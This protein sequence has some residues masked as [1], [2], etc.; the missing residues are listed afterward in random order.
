ADEKPWRNLSAGVVSR[1]LRDAS[2]A[3]AGTWTY[4]PSLNPLPDALHPAREAVRTVVSPLG[5]KSESFFSV[6]LDD[7]YAD[8]SK[9]DYSLPFTRFAAD[10]AGRFLS[11]RTWD[12]AAGA[13]N[14]ALER[15]TYVAYERD[16]GL[17]NGSDFQANMDRNRRVSA[18]KTVYDDDGGRYEAAAFSDFDG[19]GHYR[20]TDLSGTF[21][22]GNTASQITKHNAGRGTYPASFV[23]P[24][25]GEP[26]VL[27]TYTEQTR[28]EGGVTAKTEACFDAAT[29]FCCAP[30]RSGAARSG[31][32]TTWSPSSP[33]P[34]ATSPARSTTAATRR[35]WAPASSAAWA[36]PPAS[37]GSTMAGSTACAAR[38]STSTPRAARCRSRAWTRT[39]TRAPA[40]SGRAAT[41]RS[42]APPSNMTPWAG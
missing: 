17:L 27:G 35:P 28:T 34:E 3:V 36:C 8:W 6:A 30:G 42:S 1:T 16:E 14:C 23:M 37:T 25:I 19:L 15:S 10:G 24:G 11:T 38:P 32:P 2:G 13:V 18:T 9:L 21:D 41:P 5:D 31:M 7:S 26:W 29:G 4:T 39:S 20:R 40:W 12:C 22:A 33:R